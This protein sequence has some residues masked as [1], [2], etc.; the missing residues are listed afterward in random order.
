[1]YLL[2]YFLVP[3]FW[4]Q[5]NCSMPADT[6]YFPQNMQTE[7]W[8]G[9]VMRFSERDL[10]TAKQ[11]CIKQTCGK[12]LSQ[13]ISAMNLRDRKIPRWMCVSSLCARTGLQWNLKKKKTQNLQQSTWNLKKKSVQSSEEVVREEWC[14]F[15]Q[16]QYPQLQNEQILPKKQI[17]I[18]KPVVPSLIFILEKWK[19]Y[20]LLNIVKA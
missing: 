6:P 11:P 8:K 18:I 5:Y 13:E 3:H 17:P 12:R 15:E 9:N 19:L 16:I 2:T 1:M 20:I 4:L 10:D 14:L 7:M